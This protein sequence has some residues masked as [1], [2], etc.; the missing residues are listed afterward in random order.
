M[1][2]TTLTISEKFRLSSISHFIVC[3]TGS[4]YIRIGKNCGH[5]VECALLIFGYYKC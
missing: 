1:Y 4:K 3:N 5:R 2:L